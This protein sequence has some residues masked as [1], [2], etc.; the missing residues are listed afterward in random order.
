MPMTAPDV[1]VVDDD[2]S[3]MTLTSQWLKD[4]GYRV[5][6]VAGAQE[7]IES[8][9]VRTPSVV[10]ANTRLRGHGGLWLAQ[11]LR[12][13]LPDV[14]LVLTSADSTAGPLFARAGLGAFDYLEKPFTVAQLIEAVDRGTRW[15][16]QRLVDRRQR[17][18]A[19]AEHAAAVWSYDADSKTLTQHADWLPSPV[20]VSRLVTDL[21]LARS[22]ASAPSLF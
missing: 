2:P 1:L 4:G 15:H 22:G 7:A 16:E 19:E 10:V 9:E 12:T 6:I 21:L 5:E 18:A 20:A 3:A 13:R 11:Q 14:A 8:L 17:D